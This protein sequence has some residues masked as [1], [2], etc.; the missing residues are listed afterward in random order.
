MDIAWALRNGTNLLVQNKNSSTPGLDALVLLNFTLKK[1]KEYIYTNPDKILTDRQIKKYFTVIKK[2]SK[3]E[4]I[5]YITNQKEFYGFKFFVDKRVLI[6][7]PETELIIDEVKKIYHPGDVIA[8]IGTG[9]ACIAISL[10]KNYK[11]TKIFASDI[12]DT[13]LRVAKINAKKHRVKINFIKGDLLKPFTNKRIDI[14]VANLPYGD[15]K[16]WSKRKGP[17]TIGLQFEP[18]IALYSKKAGL[19]DLQR[20]IKQINGLK[21]RPKYVLLEIDTNQEIIIKK[22]IKQILPHSSTQTKKD[23]AGLRRLLIIKRN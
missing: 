1:S 4:P 13:A 20:L 10:G 11:N 2:R 12:S 3:G 8:D 16:V 7:R 9:S 14:I 15:K 21:H 23:L 19:N 18:A 6:P 17:K 5:A 22:F